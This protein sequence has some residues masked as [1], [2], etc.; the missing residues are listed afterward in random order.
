M[1]DATDT[2]TP[3][4]RTAATELLTMLCARDPEAFKHDGEP[5]KPLAKTP[6]GCRVLPREVGGATENTTD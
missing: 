5:P 2:Q 3:S 1:V 4:I 6:D